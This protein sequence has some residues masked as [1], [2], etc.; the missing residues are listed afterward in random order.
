MSEYAVLGSSW[1][2]ARNV[3]RTTE[4]PDGVLGAAANEATSGIGAPVGPL[5]RMSRSSWAPMLARP[6]TENQNTALGCTGL[7]P[8]GAMSRALGRG[9]EH[10]CAGRG[11]PAGTRSNALTRAVRTPSWRTFMTMPGVRRELHPKG[12]VHTRNGVLE[13][14]ACHSKL[15]LAIMA[16]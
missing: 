11:P 6:R 13:A 2:S 10:A 5:I 14:P 8:A 12:R 7:P 1:A 4:T 15:R 9:G 16:G 3:R